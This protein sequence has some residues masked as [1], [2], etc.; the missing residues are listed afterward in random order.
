MNVDN[1]ENTSELCSIDAMPPLPPL[2]LNSINTKKIP[3]AYK[4]AAISCNMFSI[5]GN[6]GSGKSTLLSLLKNSKKFNS[7]QQQ[8]NRPIV[9]IP[10]PVDEW[11][12][13]KDPNTNETIIEKFYANQDKYAFSFQMM[14]YITRLSII[15]KTMRENP[16][17]VLISERCL[18]T[19][20]NI[21]A[22]MLYDNGKISDIEFQIYTRW[23]EEFKSNITQSH[24]YVTTPP[25]LCHSRIQKRNRIG[26]EIPIEY[27][28][29][30]DRYHR[31]W[32]NKPYV[33][34]IDGQKKFK[35]PVVFET[36]MHELLYS[37]N[38]MIPKKTIDSLWA[39]HSIDVIEMTLNGC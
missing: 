37:I 32:L 18:D 7:I 17:A 15:R 34:Y 12:T 39:S 11:L 13:I 16:N 14:A 24:I 23:F 35:D 19:D 36:L 3:Q 10:E 20:R 1:Q 31:K 6:I 30:C 29:E 4:K 22:Q 38:P 5:E 8:L 27:I 21:F 33:T 26:E 25:E 28:I 9:F 2:F